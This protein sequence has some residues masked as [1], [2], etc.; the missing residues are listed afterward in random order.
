[1]PD[2]MLVE[3]REIEKSGMVEIWSRRSRKRIL[4]EQS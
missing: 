4:K 2:N 1:M 3:L